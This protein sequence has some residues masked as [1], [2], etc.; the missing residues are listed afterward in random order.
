MTPALKAWLLC[1]ILCCG[2][3]WLTLKLPAL[4]QSPEP[5]PSSVIAMNP[6]PEE[7]LNA[8]L[9]DYR[10]GDYLRAIAQWQQALDQNPSP[11]TEIRLHQNLANAYQRLG[12]AP[13]TAIFHWQQVLEL[14]ASMPESESPSSSLA[15]A[16]IRIEQAQ[17]YDAMGQHQ[18]AIDLLDEARGQLQGD[19]PSELALQGALGNAYSALGRYEYAITAHEASLEQAQVLERPQAIATALSNLANTHGFR[20]RRAY[21]QEEVAREE[22]EDAD[23]ERAQAQFERDRQA[24]ELRLQ[25][26][27]ELGESVGGITQVRSLLNAHRLLQEFFSERQEERERI[28]QQLEPLLTLLPP[29][30]EKIF[31]LIYLAQQQPRSQQSHARDLLETAITLSRTID[32]PRAE[33]FALGTLGTL[34]EQDQQYETALRLT[35]QAQFTAQEIS[36]FD[37]LYRWQQQA[38]RIHQHTGEFSLALAQYRAA[39]NSLDYLRGDLIATS[40]DLQFEFRDAVE[41]V[42]RELI[43]LLLEGDTP[44]TYQ[45]KLQETLDILERL[46]LAELRDFFGDDCVEVAQTVVQENGQL[47][48][49]TAVI[50]YSILLDESAV[51]ILQEADGTL[52]SYTVPHSRKE[53]EDEVNTF[54]SLLE[55][56]G[57][58]EYLKPAQRL[59]DWLVRPLQADLEAIAPE[60]LV[61]IQDGVLRKTPVAALHDGQRFLVESYALATT[62]SLRLTTSGRRN[63]QFG[64]TLIAGLT[65]E[66]PPFAALNNVEREVREVQGLM[67]GVSLLDED[68]TV[69]SLEQELTQKPYSI[70]H[71]ATHGKFGVDAQGTFLLAFD[72]RITIEAMDQLLRSRRRSGNSRQPLDLLVLSAC[73][74]AAGDNRSAL[75]IAG[76]AVRAGAKTA[77]ASLWFINDEATVPLITNFYKELQ[78]PGITKAQAL[79]AAQQKAI[80]SQF[81]SHPGVWSPF[82][83]IGTWR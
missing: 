2:S 58:N 17:L 37:S 75:G 32:D 38:A 22:G 45:S 19:R 27:L 64:Q 4:S 5:T 41:P 81:Y 72:D 52:S 24:I 21:Y 53:I 7:L 63:A 56:R 73:Q 42:Y 54:R 82:I 33:S 18:R 25:Q 23:A 14:A 68:F 26:S 67:G 44:G 65:V 11:A 6:S 62:P 50:V 46:K 28:R 8:G 80:D 70:V 10:R 51:L 31:A 29:S 30:R 59:Y 12:H 40:R 79:K 47:S 61:F 9:D 43:A 57:T 71:L 60:T 39:T 78:T 35:Q 48:D 20:A 16:Q 49:S 77:L 55:K 83:L 66:I 3:F 36:A 34:Y 15:Q 13:Q 1:L 74:T 69:G 76:V